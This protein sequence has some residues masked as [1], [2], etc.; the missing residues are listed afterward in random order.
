MRHE[1]RIRKISVIMRVFFRAHAV[2]NAGVII[3]TPCF[4]HELAALLQHFNLPGNFVFRRAPHAAEGIHVFDL[5]L[6]TQ[7]LL[8]FEP[9]ANVHVASH[10]ALFHVAV[11]HTAVLKNALEGV[12]IFIS[13]IRAGDVRLGH[14]LQQRH[15]R[16]VEIN[17]TVI[18]KMKTLAHILLQ[19]GAIDPHGFQLPTQL[20]FHKA[21]DGG[22]KIQLGKLI[23]LGVVRVKIIF[24]IPFGI[25]RH[26]AI[27]E[28]TGQCR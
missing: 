17:P 26:I 4:L 25:A 2:R 21:G 27:Q 13:H 24:P 16:P 11:T 19:V 1:V 10:L 12:Q 14:N 28:K 23:I 7:L 8:P 6:F 5:N 18:G 3:P 20:E 22:W 9:N 15:S